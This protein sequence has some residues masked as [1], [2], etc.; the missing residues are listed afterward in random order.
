MVA[1]LFDYV[2]VGG[3]DVRFLILVHQKARDRQESVHVVRNSLSCG[4]PVFA[5]GDGLVETGGELAFI[6][7]RIF[8]DILKDFY[9]LGHVLGLGIFSERI[10]YYFG[11]ACY[12]SF[13]R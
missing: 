9:L 10:L 12:S 11:S 2:E 1:R 3:A 5:T 8:E 4:V 7:F 6:F 13:L